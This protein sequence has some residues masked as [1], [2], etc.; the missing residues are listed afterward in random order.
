[1]GLGSTRQTPTYLG[2][3]LRR[4]EGR[5]GRKKAAVAV[6]HNILV[7]IYHLLAEETCDEE[8]RYDHLRPKQEARERQRAMK[9]LERLGYRVTV[10]RPA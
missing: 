1:M 3:T 4:L 6:V 8:A 7:M 10:A 5:L 2:R 9:A